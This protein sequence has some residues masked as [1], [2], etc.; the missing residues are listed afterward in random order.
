MS[1]FG[2]IKLAT[3][4]TVGITVAVVA[5]ATMIPIKIALIAIKAAIKK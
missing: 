3:V 4:V 1:T 5:T 2:I